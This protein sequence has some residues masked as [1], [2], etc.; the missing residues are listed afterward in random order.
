[1]QRRRFIQTGF[2]AL[3]AT[4]LPEVYNQYTH[5]SRIGKRPSE[6]RIVDIKR[7]TVKLPFRPAPQRAMDREIPH[8]RYCEIITVELSG[9][10]VGTGEGLL[11]Y[12]WGVSSEEAIQSALG[13][14]AADLMWNDELGAGLQMALFDAVGKAGNVPAYRLLGNQ[15]YDTTP[16]SWWNIDMPTDDM[17]SECQEALRLG[18][19]AYKTKGRPW[20]D[21]WDQTETC[22]KSMPE[23]FKIDMDFN[24]TLLTAKQ[25]IP[26]LKWM[27]QFPQVDI[28]ESPIPQADIKGN[29]AITKAVR[30]GVSL[31]YGTP[32]PKDV[33]KHDVCDGFVIGG[34][35]SRVMRQS[36]VAETMD[37][38]FW[39]QLVGAGLTAAFS[40]HF[41]AVCSAATWPAVNCHQLYVHDMLKNPIR[42]REGFAAIPDKPGLGVEL[43]WSVVNRYAVEKPA[44]RPD[45]ARMIET[46]YPDGRRMYTANNGTVNFMLNPAR[47]PGN[48]PYF[49][50]GVDSKLLPNDGSTR[51]KELYTRSRKEG[52]VVIE[53]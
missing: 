22:A 13:S 18:Y 26:I 44:A 4:T 17:L 30:A 47:S 52:P 37:M 51:W 24:E 34:G 40:L 48:M 6:L 43:D 28:Y 50:K 27:D 41:G 36:H 42:V 19:K 5:A 1:M 45:P 21:L 2:A 8:W 7:Q 11:Y 49:E 23:D 16:L 39:L 31:H 38:R 35:A 14:N 10:A 46:T 33:V 15:V 12:S 9:G 29:A 3:A 20:F 53:P 32:T 25:G